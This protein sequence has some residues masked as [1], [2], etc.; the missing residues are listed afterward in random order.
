MNL[1]AGAA[2]APLRIQP[3]SADSMRAWAVFLKDP[4]PIHLD[5]QAVQACGLGN[6]LINQGPANLAYII[7]ML[8]QALPGAR[9]RELD[10]RY[11]DNVF[12]GD[13]VE[14]SGTIAQID[15]GAPQRVTCDIWLR[16]EGRGP[17]ITGSA[18]LEI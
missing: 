18:V 6:R 5:R 7:S 1:S 10:V 11:V 8:R 14:A 4:N 17:V 13:A 3:V 16:A 9:L 2:L 15:S 12:E